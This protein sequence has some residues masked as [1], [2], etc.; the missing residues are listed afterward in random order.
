M[1]SGANVTDDERDELFRYLLVV[2]RDAGFSWVADEATAL[3]PQGIEEQVSA[4]E[5][6]G[7]GRPTRGEFRATR[8]EFAPMERIELLVS[9]VER[10]VHSAV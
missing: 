3:V 7:L 1:C 5:W 6:T 9:A 4:S 2:V 8:R 10:V